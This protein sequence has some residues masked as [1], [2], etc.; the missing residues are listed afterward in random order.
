MRLASL[1]LSALLLSTSAL[2][3][4]EGVMHLKMP[5]SQNTPAEMTGKV[6]AKKHMQRTD[7]KT[8]MDMSTIVDMKSKKVWNLMHAQKMA[9]VIE[10]GEAGSKTPN[11]STEDIDGCLKKEGF[12]KVGSGAANR[13]PCTIYENEVKDKGEDAKI[14]LWRPNDLKEVAAVKSEVTTDDGVIT[15]NITDIKTVTLADSVFKV[16]S[17]Y[18]TM[19]MKGM[20]NMF[21][22]R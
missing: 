19:D 12:K 2:A 9:M 10:A 16:P 20:G 13:H 5:A 8:P 15:V 4:W 14:K 17:N 6:R 3:D 11:C 7:F 21:K 1:L 18:K 22:K